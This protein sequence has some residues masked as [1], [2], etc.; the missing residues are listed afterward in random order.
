M[1]F[2]GGLVTKARSEETWLTVLSPPA[3]VGDLIKCF[4]FLKHIRVG[5]NQR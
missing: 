5:V 2:L 3:K 4:S 1:V